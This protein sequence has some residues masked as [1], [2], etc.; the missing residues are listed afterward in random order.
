M[1]R[2]AL[3]QGFFDEQAAAFVAGTGLTITKIY[4]GHRPYFDGEDEQRAVWEITF[5]REGRKA[6]TWTFGDSVKDSYVVHDLNTAL[7]RAQPIPPWVYGSLSFKAAL[8]LGGGT[9][10]VR[11]Q[12]K[13]TH[14]FRLSPAHPEPSDYS[15]L[16]AVEKYAPD[17]FD[18]FCSDYGYDTD[19]RKALDTYQQV[20]KQAAAIRR[21]F[22]EAELEKLAEI[23]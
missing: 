4:L 16:A 22:T 23:Q 9:F 6:Y 15:L 8:R 14:S 2:H 18:E 11:D 5:S 13:V 7:M 17:T 1:K 19:S 12:S 20:Q 3:A 21:M 10:S